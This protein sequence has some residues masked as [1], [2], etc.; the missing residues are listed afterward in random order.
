MSTQSVLY[1]E[2]GFRRAKTRRPL[3]NDFFKVILE[4]KQRARSRRELAHLSCLDIKDIGYPADLEAE[5]DKPF[6]RR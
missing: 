6:W 1:R 3:S 5:K 4:W 2:N